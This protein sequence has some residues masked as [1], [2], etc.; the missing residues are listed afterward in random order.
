MTLLSFPLLAL[1]Q[2]QAPAPAPPAASGR[3]VL[4]RASGQFETRELAGFETADPRALGFHLLRFEGLAPA[5]VPPRTESSA[6]IELANGDRLHGRVRGGRAELLDVE[7]AGGVRIGVAI[8]ELASL[9]FPARIPETWAGTLAAP[10]EGDALYRRTREGLDPDRGGTEEFTTEGVRFHG[11]VGSRLIDWSE[12]AALF[13]EGLPPERDSAAEPAA[14]RV[15]VDLVDA[16]RLRGRLEKVDAQG[17]RMTT[18]NGESLLLPAAVVGQLLVED[19]RV[20]FLSDLEPS[21]APPSAPFGDDL[22]MVW[23]HQVD[24][25]VGGEPLQ[26]GGRVWPRGIGVHAPSRLAW[27]LEGW[28]T[29]RGSVAV[30]DAAR[31]L[32]AR[33]S[34]VFRVLL[35]G[36]EAWKSPVVRGGDAPLALPPI[37]VSKARELV[38]EVDATGDGHAG[39]RAD[40]LALLL[41]RG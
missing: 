7:V 21:S 17:V 11:Q 34:V 12:V 23:P 1:A 39:D 18:H 26:A 41:S 29:L 6:V 38:L 19:D 14:A 5:A 24:R 20:A 10:E 27:K 22:G 40:W 33:G 2:A 4:E 3:V 35:D 37:D 28:K 16:G 8:D 9:V 30:D 31:R 13:V 32:S 36:A 15:V 25:A